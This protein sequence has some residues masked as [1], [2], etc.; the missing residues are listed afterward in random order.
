MAVHDDLDNIRAV[1]L[2]K[3]L[4]Q[5]RI[6]K[7]RTVGRMLTEKGFCHLVN[8]PGIYQRLVSLQVDI[9]VCIDLPGRFRN[10]LRAACGFR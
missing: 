3:V 5:Y 9:Y 7:C 2:L 8:I 1:E 10:T 6:Y 4:G